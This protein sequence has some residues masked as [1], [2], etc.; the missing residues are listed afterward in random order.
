[1]IWILGFLVCIVIIILIVRS[2]IAPHEL[3]IGVASK[4]LLIYKDQLIE[5]E[6]DLEK[7]ILNKIESDAARIE[8]SRRI[9]LADKRSKSENT[10]TK[11]PKILSRLVTATIFLFI[12]IGTFSTYA[13]IGNPTLK[14]M[15]L[16][17]RLAQAQENRS[18]RISQENAELLVPDENIEAP[19]DYLDLVSKLRSAMQD[20]PNDMQ[21][22]RL[23]ALHEFRLGK[24][25]SA[26]KA[27][28]QIINI[29]GNKATAKDFVDFAEVMIVATNGYV[30]PKAETTLRRALELT[31]NDGRARY[32]SGLSMAQNGRP[33]VALRLWEN[34]L[35]EG[36]ENAPWIPLIKDQIIDIARLAGVNLSEDQLPGPNSEQIDSAKNMSDQER[37][38]MIQGMVTSLSN[39]LATEGGSVNEWARLIRAL[40][41][42]G[43][44][45]SASNTWKEAQ[46]VFSKSA[47]DLEILQKAAKA[48]KVSQ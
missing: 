25:R 10:I 24:Y 39:R 14:D 2:I 22:L 6:K 35:N 8:V 3:D 43:E 5:V 31:P 21:G 7:G 19:D 17:S 16:K 37:M 36:P 32:Y 41:V 12:L 40:G 38:E 33:D 48:A 44:T 13:Y 11:D 46:N 27:H 4:D 47:K 30:S 42:L 26:R 45:T 9:L 18:N 1:M 34:L 15:P 29:L 23:L 20:R 28:T